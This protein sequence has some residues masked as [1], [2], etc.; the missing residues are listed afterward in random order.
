MTTGYSNQDVAREMEIEIGHIGIDEQIGRELMAALD[1]RF[2]VCQVACRLLDGYTYKSEAV[3]Y[4]LGLL[5]GEIVPVDGTVQETAHIAAET[6]LQA[7]DERC[8]TLADAVA[9]M[10]GAVQ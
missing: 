4:R 9:L 2:D 7:V 5:A 8:D 10:G 6:I 1:G 3:R